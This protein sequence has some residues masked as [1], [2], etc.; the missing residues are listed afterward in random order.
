M[1]GTILDKYEVLQKVGEGGMA[2]VYRGRHTTLGRDVAI[3]ILHPHL[4]SSTRNRKRFAR[5][6]RAIEHLRHDNILEIFDYSGA[7]AEDCYIVTEFVGGRTLTG[8]MDEHGRLPSEVASIIG[9]ALARALTYAHD[10]GVLHRDLK[11][12]NVMIRFDGTVKLMDFGIARFLDESQV[13]MTGALVGSPAFMSPEQAKEGDLDRRSDL[14]SLGTLLFF[15]ASGHL[16][17]S[18]SNPSLILKNIIEGNRP[19]LAELAPSVSATLCD[20]VER[21][22]Q[23]DREERFDDARQVEERLRA[24]LDEVRIDPDDPRWSLTA[25]LDDSAAYQRRLDDHLE[26]VL[27]EQGR[28]LLTAGDALDA[29]RLLNRLLSIDP[30]NAEVVSLVQGLHVEEES[31]GGA[32]RG[33]WV[34]AGVGAVLAA[35]AFLVVGLATGAIPLFGPASPSGQPSS[36]PDEA[37]PRDTPTAIAPA[38]LVPD[39]PVEADSP[40]DTDAELPL[41]TRVPLPGQPTRPSVQPPSPRV[42]RDS[43]RDDGSADASSGTAD[44]GELPSDAVQVPPPAPAR[45]CLEVRLDRYYADVWIDGRSADW[46]T[47]KPGCIDVEPGAHRV[48]LIHSLLE[49]DQDILV[50]VAEGQHLKITPDVR[51]SPITVRFPEGWDTSCVVRVDGSPVGPLAEVGSDLALERS[52]SREVA[53]VCG[54]KVRARQSYRVDAYK[55]VDFP[56]PE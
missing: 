52:G 19:S 21:L 38:V 50:D 53:L 3:K 9:I 46:R 33:M 8:F 28:E 47:N 23:S 12:D 34:V 4:S 54:G 14:F 48:R 30:D 36:P 39:K 29:L 7:D 51:W 18:G 45:S 56:A 6:A 11:P 55:Q 44:D 26:T 27:L 42:P 17:F 20:V 24:S 41:T 31:E 35:V 49:W 37:G 1:I 15:L 43:P 25:W 32:R 10:A 5:E 22:L 13:T 16:P 40:V 2:T